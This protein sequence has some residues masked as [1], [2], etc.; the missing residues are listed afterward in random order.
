MWII[1]FRLFY[2]ENKNENKTIVYAV[3]ADYDHN[4]VTRSWVEYKQEVSNSCV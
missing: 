4:R 1:H 2:F 3:H